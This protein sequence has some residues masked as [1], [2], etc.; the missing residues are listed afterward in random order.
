[1]VCRANLNPLSST[2]Q[3]YTISELKNTAEGIKSRVDEAEDPISELKDKVGKNSQK[4]QEKEK[5]L[6]KNEEGLGELQDNM[7]R[8]NICIRGIPEGE[9]AKKIK[10]V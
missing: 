6:K 9:G 7:K 1:M 3:G 4:E 10:P 2:S 8:N 5:R